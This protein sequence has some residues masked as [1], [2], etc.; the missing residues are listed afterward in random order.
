MSNWRYWPLVVLNVLA[1]ATGALLVLNLLSGP[2]ST[3]EVA[4][5]SYPGPPTDLRISSSAPTADSLL[6]AG[7]SMV[8]AIFTILEVLVD[9]HI[10]TVARR[11]WFR[12]RQ[13]PTPRSSGFENPPKWAE[14]LLVLFLPH[15]HAKDIPGDIEEVYRDTILPK[16][17]LSFAHIWYVKEVFVTIV[18]LLPLRILRW[19]T[20]AWLY[21]HVRRWIGR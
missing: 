19:I 1:L 5:R 13:T 6:V 2:V 14:E 18:C 8:V 9:L 11:G 15:N 7:L 20:F 21:E 17:G 4:S 12:H 10:F 16:Y 3:L